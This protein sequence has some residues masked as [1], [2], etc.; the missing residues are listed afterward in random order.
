M[1]TYFIRKLKSVIG[2]QKKPIA[3]VAAEA[4][5]GRFPAPLEHC[6]KSQVASKVAEPGHP[7]T[8]LH[9][10]AAVLLVDP[11]CYRQCVGTY[12]SLFLLSKALESAAAR[13]TCSPSRVG[14][15]L[16]SRFSADF[17]E[18][19]GLGTAEKVKRRTEKNR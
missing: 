15:A 14:K 18:P 9:P 16:N 12:P 13:L 11:S 10:L 17:L 1:R 4:K 6:Q 5:P 7:T 19:D 2:P 8:D 3:I